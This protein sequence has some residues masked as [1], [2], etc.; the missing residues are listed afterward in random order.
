M[1][2][3]V[4]GI[5]SRI[6]QL[7]LCIA[8]KNM[9]KLFEKKHWLC[10]QAPRAG[11]SAWREGKD[12]QLARVAVRLSSSHATCTSLSRTYCSCF[13]EMIPGASATGTFLHP[14]PTGSRPLGWEGGFQEYADHLLLGPPCSGPVSRKIMH[15]LIQPGRVLV[16][17]W[18]RH[19]LEF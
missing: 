10:A 7:N 4:K 14:N 18:C 13:T 5:S 19:S 9:C 12:S 15:L 11:F 1:I 6:H 3:Q 17:S 2:F 8:T 16:N